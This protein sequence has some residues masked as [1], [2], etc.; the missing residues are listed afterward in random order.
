MDTLIRFSSF[1][2]DIATIFALFGIVYAYFFSRK[3]IHF[4]TIEKCINDYRQLY[5]KYEDKYDNPKFLG[6][7]LDLVN[8]ELFYIEK[9]YLP[10]EVAEEWIDGMIDYL[11]FL[12]NSELIP[13]KK[14]NEF[15]TSVNVKNRLYSYPRILHFIKV[16]KQIDFEKVFLPLSDDEVIELRSSER[17][18]L[19]K[20]LKNNL[21]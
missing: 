12:Y 4:S 19:I 2:S 20:L 11:P 13:S 17:K 6:Q 3:Q 8:E 7:Y 10:K 16:E 15:H 18:K 9:G 14:F 1:F 21:K 5:H